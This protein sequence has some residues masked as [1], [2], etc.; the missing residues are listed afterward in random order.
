MGAIGKPVPRKEGRA[1]VTGAARYVDDLAVPG[2]LHGVTVRSPVARGRIRGIQFGTAI[3]WDEIRGRRRRRRPR[4]ELRHPHLEDDQPCLADGVVNHREEPVLLLAHADRDLVEEARRAV[5]AR[6][7]AAAGGLRRSRTRWRAATVIWGDDNVFKSFLVE[8]GDVDA[9]LGGTRTSSS[10]ASTRPARRS[11][12][13]S[14]PR[15]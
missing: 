5:D 2:M 14:S 10:R 7:R 9:A 1:K 11:S 8:K 4:E 15:G 6:H 13:T 3:P 12:S